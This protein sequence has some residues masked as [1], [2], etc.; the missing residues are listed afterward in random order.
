MN[1]LIAGG[2][3][4]IGQS[5]IDV[6]QH[7]HQL[8]FIGRNTHHL[9]KLFKHLGPCHDWH[10]LDDIQSSPDLIINLCGLNIGDAAWTPKIKQE[11]IDSR[12]KTSEKLIQWA[13]KQQIKPRMMC[14]NAVGIYGLQNNGDEAVFTED[15]PIKTKNPT[16]FLN[17]IGVRWEEALRPAMEYG[18]PV[19]TTRF[20]VVLKKNQGILKK[21][22]LSFYLGLGSIIGDGTQMFSWVHHKDM[23]RALIFLIEHPDL[24][25][26]FNITSPHPVTQKT[27]AKALANSMHRPLLLTLPAV[28][29]KLMFGEMGECLLLRGQK[30][31]PKRLLDAGFVFDYPTIEQALSSI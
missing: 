15:S 11:L 3:G 21:L 18:M 28:V 14:A 29:V 30:V 16:D 13:I 25:G 31:I 4:L 24:T 5:L 17:E 19:V 12:V 26:P 2:S 10:G 7:S 8:T 27:F 20:G 6:L 22:N 23:V 9:L 1:I